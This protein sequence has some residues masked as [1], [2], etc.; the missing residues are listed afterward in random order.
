MRKFTIK[1][2]TALSALF[3][4]N[5]FAQSVSKCEASPHPITIQQTNGTTLS[6]IGKGNSINSYTETVEGYTIVKNENGLYEYAKQNENG[7]LVPSGILATNTISTDELP[8]SI[9]QGLRET[10]EALSQKLAIFYASNKTGKTA[11]DK[12]SFPTT[13]KRKVLLLLIEYPDLQSSTTKNDF[14]RLMNEP[15]YNGTGSFRDFFLENSFNQLDLSV[16]VFG[17]YQAANEHAYYGREKGYDVARELAGEAIDAA[18]AAG[19]DFSQYDNDK[20]GS[21]DGLVLVHSGPGAEEGGLNQYIWSHRWSLTNGYERFYDGINIQEYMFNP[22]R[23]VFSNAMTGI[24]VFCHEFGHGLGIPDLYDTDDSN[25]ASAGLGEWSLMAGGPWVNGEKTPA[26]MDA[27]SKI[28]LK[29]QKPSSIFCSGQY[30]LKAAALENRSLILRTKNPGEYFLLENRQKVKYDAFLKGTGLAIWHVDENVIESTRYSNRIN[31]DENVKGIDLEEADGKNQLDEN[32]NRGDNGDLFPGS[33][34]K[35]NF[36]SSTN[37]NALLN[38]GSDEGISISG[39]T[40]SNGVITFNIVVPKM[41][42]IDEYVTI[43]PGEVYSI[44]GKT[45]S[46]SGTY[47]NTLKAKMGCDSTVI[48]HLT[49]AT[50]SLDLGINYTNNKKTLLSNDLDNLRQWY[51][52]ENKKIIPGATQETFTPKKS[53]SYAVILT[54]F[55]CPSEVDTSKCLYVGLLA[56]ES[57]NTEWIKL[58]PNPANTQLTLENNA[59]SA[60]QVLISDASG[61]QIALFSMSEKQQLNIDLSEYQAGYYLVKMSSSEGEVFT[62]SFIKN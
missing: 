52:C 48:T 37:P 61:K 31:A 27:W 44:N 18:E 32:T 38:D 13:G 29:W 14:N 36:N 46:Q 55:E 51:D 24:G 1:V 62:T 2:L 19:V 57:P 47:T 20:D 8:S 23:R 30:T 16:D 54:S 60:T 22:E 42:A 6:I 26:S 53:G 41:N 59:S 39:I 5:S 17:W 3:V 56:V 11:Q 45:Y 28:E 49:K 7:F 50:P 33:S 25:G 58:Y 43:C 15:N 34:I 35:R 10:K 4:S 40:E 9:H 21:I 12:A